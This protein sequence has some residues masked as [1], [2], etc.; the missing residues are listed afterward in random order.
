MFMVL[1]S[2]Q[3]H[4]ESSLGSF[5]ECRTTPIGR[6][7]SDQ[8]RRLRLWVRLYRLPEST[9]TIAIYCYYTTI[10]DTTACLSVTSIP[11]TILAVMVLY[12]HPIMV[13]TTSGSTGNLLEFEILSENTGNLVFNCFSWKF[14]CNGSIIDW[15]AWHPVIK[16]SCGLVIVKLA[17]PV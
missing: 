14:L 9:P 4:C 6:R 13:S 16:L 15:R 8:A 3:S 11:I 12:V 10:A 5:D 17:T 7:P 2:W 1:S